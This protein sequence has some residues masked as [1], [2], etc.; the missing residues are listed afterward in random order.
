MFCAATGRFDTAL[1]DFSGIHVSCVREDDG[2]CCV[3]LYVCSHVVVVF[4]LGGGV[5]VC[6]CVCC[7]YVLEVNRVGVSVVGSRPAKGTACGGHMTTPTVVLHSAFQ[8]ATHPSA[9]IFVECVINY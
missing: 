2:V 3:F 5:C 9:C 4:L 1:Y 8:T 6:V 7:S